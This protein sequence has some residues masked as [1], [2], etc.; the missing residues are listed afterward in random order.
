MLN[1]QISFLF[2]IKWGKKQLGPFNLICI[3]SRQFYATLVVD[4]IKI[5]ETSLST[6][7]VNAFR[8]CVCS[9]VFARLYGF[10]SSAQ[11]HFEMQNKDEKVRTKQRRNNVCEQKINI[12]F[13]F[14]ATVI[15]FTGFIFQL[16]FD[17][18]IISQQKSN[19]FQRE[20]RSE[21]IIEMYLSKQVRK[22]GEKGRTEHVHE[23]VL[24]F[25]SEKM[26]I[27]KRPYKS[28]CKITTI[29]QTQNKFSE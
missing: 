29:F 28:S 19:S 10:Y 13:F 23:V 21:R 17:G 5:C 14:S 6:T 20:E 1:V 9:G 22:G 3:V 24:I 11:M 12:L 15:L 25:S 27:R 16:L 8:F 26:S 2:N 4:Q 18:Y 7:D